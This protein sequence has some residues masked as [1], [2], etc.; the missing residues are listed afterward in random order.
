MLLI[1]Q[2][3]MVLIIVL[4]KYVFY[5]FTIKYLIVFGL[6]SKYPNTTVCPTSILYFEDRIIV[7][8]FIT[9]HKDEIVYA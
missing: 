8:S 5:I 7:S 3:Y 1:T 9:R 4:F 6:T 2:M